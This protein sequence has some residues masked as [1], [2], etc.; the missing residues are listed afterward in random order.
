MLEAYLRA[1]TSYAVT[2]RAA[3]VVRVDARP[4][5]RRYTGSAL[6]DL[7]FEPAAGG[8]GTIRFPVA[9]GRSLQRNPWLRSGLDRFERIPEATTVRDLIEAARRPA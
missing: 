9:G 6:D 7:I 5:V 3:Y 2:D 4:T 1:R 8:A